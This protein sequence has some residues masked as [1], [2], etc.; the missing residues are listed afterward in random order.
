MVIH[1]TEE[2]EESVQ[3]PTDFL[4]FSWLWP[5]TSVLLHPWLPT[6]TLG[7]NAVWFLLEPFLERSTPLGSFLNSEFPNH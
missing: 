3:E 4:W 5:D 6:G 2:R 7:P 1:K